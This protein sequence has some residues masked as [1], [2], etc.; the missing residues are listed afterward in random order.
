MKIISL[1]HLVL[2]VKNIEA[3]CQ[4]YQDILGMQVITFGEG[5]KALKFGQQKFNLH[6]AGNEFEPKANKPLP[7]AIDLC[8][9]SETPL[10]TI[11][12][13]LKTQNISIEE[14]PISRTGA[15]GDICSIYVRDPDL[16][17]IEI[18][19]YVY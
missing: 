14:G 6:Q 16:N 2:T 11:I 19:N 8:L 17:L 7:G 1:D 18:S 13:E 15:T 9:I 3:T 12:K 4:F 5:R 10:E